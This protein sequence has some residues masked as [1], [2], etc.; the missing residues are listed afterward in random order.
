MN[1]AQKRGKGS[2]TLAQ[3]GAIDHLTFVLYV[4]C[5]FLHLLD[6]FFSLPNPQ[7]SVSLL[8]L[9]KQLASL[10]S[11]L[12]SSSSTAII[13]R[14]VWFQTLPTFHFSEFQPH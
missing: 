9:N 5:F 13:R 6:Q 8:N 3:V 10:P 4:L 2:S 7:I 12:S 11:L 1:L 14:I